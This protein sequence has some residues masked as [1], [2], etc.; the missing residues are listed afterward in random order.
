MSGR[1]R[2]HL[3]A[4]AL[5]SLFAACSG[6]APREFT[7]C[8]KSI[9]AAPT[10]GYF[11]DEER[12]CLGQRWRI[13]SELYSRK[14]PAYGPRSEAFIM[15]PPTTPSTREDDVYQPTS[16]V[17][18]MPII[19]TARD[20]INQRISTQVSS[21]SLSDAPSPWPRLRALR[22]RTGKNMDVDVLLV[23]EPVAHPQLYGLC[24]TQL[25]ASADVRSR[26]SCGVRSVLN[27]RVYAEFN[28]PLAQLEHLPEIHR[29]MVDRLSRYMD[30]N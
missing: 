25:S 9:D 22:G 1:R 2:L 18:V 24:L 6:P 16:D 4:P 8:I 13:P 19:G 23:T 7:Q 27:E 14:Y 3:A 17:T 5:L 20:L 28:V 21:L 12:Q 10:D 15:R 29:S 11:R 26:T 30:H